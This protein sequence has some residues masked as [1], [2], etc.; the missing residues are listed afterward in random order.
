MGQQTVL[1]LDPDAGASGVLS[2]ALS[3]KGAQCRTESD[4]A[5]ALSLIGEGG[6]DLLISELVL[7]GVS[8]PQFLREAQAKDPDLAIIAVA[9]AVDVN[10]AIEVMNSGV[11]NLLLKP[12]SL[13]DFTFNVEK[14]LERHIL[15]REN[16]LY[17]TDLERRIEEAT[18]ELKRANAELQATKDYLES[19]LDTSLDTIITSDM[20]Y[21]VTYAN[22]GAG[23]MLGHYWNG[24]VGRNL[25]DVIVGGPEELQRVSDQLDKGPIRNMEVTLRTA[26]GRHLYVMA[27]ISRLLDG[28]GNVVST[29]SICKDITQQK[30]LEH[31]LKELTI[32]DPALRARIGLA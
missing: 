7:P 1:I 4:P 2:T 22:R 32:R 30:R 25:R 21:S 9:S 18:S 16:R 19:L 27:S 20:D 15:L 10:L 31:E 29:L 13:H 11:Y 12:F 28:D 8:S 3:R 24:L 5:A 14:A 23:E 17:Q 26:D 6:V